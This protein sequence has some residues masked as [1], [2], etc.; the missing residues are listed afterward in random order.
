VLLPPAEHA[1]CA[2]RS[3]LPPLP[4]KCR[5]R[6][7]NARYPPEKPSSVSERVVTVG[8]AG[9]MLALLRKTLA[10]SYLALIRAS[11]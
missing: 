6:P 9:L 4:G 8:Q 7:E 3:Q 10:G 5:V 2:F 11:R 1:A